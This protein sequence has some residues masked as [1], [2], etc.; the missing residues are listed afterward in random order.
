VIEYVPG[1]L[2]LT[3]RSGTTLAEIE[4]TTAEHGQWLA[5]DPSG[6]SRGTIG[7]TV[8]TASF[9]PLALGSGT[10]RDLVLG[11][12]V[13]TGLGSRIRVGGRVVKNVAGFDLVRL[14]TGAW[15]TLG[16][17]SDVSVRLHAK[18]A[19]DATFALTHDDPS[20]LL[21][22]V[23]AL[24]HDALSFHALELLN[25]DAAHAVGAG[26]GTDYVLLARATGN[27]SAVAAQRA[28]L[29]AHSRLDE[30]DGDTWARMRSIDDDMDVL[31]VSGPISD[32]ANT[33]AKVQHICA[34]ASLDGVRLRVTP[35]RGAVR[36]LI[37][38]YATQSA[39]TVDVVV[40]L[41]RDTHQVI[42]E[43]LPQ[44]AWRQLPARSNDRI[45]A[46]IRDASDPDR[47]MNFGIL[48]ENEP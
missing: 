1:D 22:V 41:S 14:H 35:H 33:L 27:A 13:V 39:R 34:S 48:G 2:V 42:G 5:L 20:R 18:P 29:A 25:P 24:K 15:G 36:V 30:I 17:I 23:T 6:S 40:Q 32:M 31:R 44:D 7:A 4:A 37:P 19:A 16:V 11:L 9:G 12:G 45:S 28:L 47:I 3:V 26:G 38:R 46:L 8:A 43:R 10:I 21:D